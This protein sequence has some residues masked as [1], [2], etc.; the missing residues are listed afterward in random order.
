MARKKKA[1]V[2]SKEIRKLARERVG[3]V[4]PAFSI[5]PKTDRKKPKHKKSWRRETD[6][7]A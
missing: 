3:T 1:F 5:R 6:E 7:I 4:K 2:V